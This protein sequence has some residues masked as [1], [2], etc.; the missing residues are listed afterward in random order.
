MEIFLV[1]VLTFLKDFSGSR[2][3]MPCK[4]ITIA[5]GN[6]QLASRTKNLCPFILLRCNQYFKS[7]SDDCP[8][9]TSKM[10]RRTT[11]LRSAHI[12]KGIIVQRTR[13]LRSA[14]QSNFFRL[15]HEFF[16]KPRSNFI[17]RI[18]TKHKLQNFK[19]TSAFRLNLNFKFLVL[20][21]ICKQTSRFA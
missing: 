12:A 19:Q 17:L 3:A 6:P 11:W 1:K 18:S 10:L 14:Y 2:S 16:Y 5:T 13:R 8:I 15:Y 21:D 7:Q 4:T 9:S 20:S